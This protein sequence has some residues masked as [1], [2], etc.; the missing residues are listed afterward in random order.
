MV[1]LDVLVNVANVIYLC[2]YSVR[3]IFWLRI[4]TVLG[5]SFLMPYY[6]FQ[7]SPLWTPIGWNTFFLCINLYWIARLLAERRPAPFTEEERHLYAIALQNLSERDA[8]K[9]LRMADRKTVPA[10]TVLV[11]Q[12]NLVADLSLIV[13]G[14]VLVEEDARQVDNLTEG[15]FVGAVALLAQKGQFSAP[16]TVRTST[17][18][19]LLTWSFAELT[20]EFSRNSNLQVAIEASLGMEVSRWLQTTR[21]VLLRA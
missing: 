12:G 11:M 18:A 6:Y 19:T 4:L 2:S 8:F 5:I 1:G 16:V 13:E 3:D 20:S 7:G 17:P 21:Q 15:N 10:G 9:F 14:E